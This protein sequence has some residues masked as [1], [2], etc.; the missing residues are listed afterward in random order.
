MV[1]TLQ[2]L[3]VAHRPADADEARSLTTMLDLL[4][5]LAKPLSRYKA[6]AHFT[7]SALLVDVSAEKMALLYH[8]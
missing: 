3:L 1:P 4:P 6:E 8:G 2:Q 5:R 7:A